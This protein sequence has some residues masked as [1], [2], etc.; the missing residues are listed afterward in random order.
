[1]N[2][3]QGTGYRLQG[4]GY[5]LQVTGNYG[6]LGILAGISMNWERWHP[7]R[8]INVLMNGGSSLYELVIL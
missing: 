6:T 3:S 1:M 7:C 2:R 8:H 4:T 5:R